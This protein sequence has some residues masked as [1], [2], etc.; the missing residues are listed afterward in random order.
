M[1]L[2]GSVARSCACG[3]ESSGS[4]K[5]GVFWLIEQQSASEG[6]MCLMKLISYFGN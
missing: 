6:R 5:C 3:S 1:E 4:V 2:T